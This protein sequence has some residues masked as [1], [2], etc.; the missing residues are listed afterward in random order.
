[1]FISMF[2][3]AARRLSWFVLFASILGIHMPANGSV[4]AA[5]NHSERPNV[6]R[7]RDDARQPL[8]TLT[9]A[10]VQEGDTVLDL[11]AGG[12]WY[13]ELLSRIVGNSGKVFAHNDQVIWSFVKDEMQQRTQGNRLS[14]VVRIDDA[15]IAHISLPENSVDVVFSSLNYHDMYFVSY[16]RN[17]VTTQ[18]REH[19][20]DPVK[21]M[22]HIS[23]LLKDDGHVVIIDH[24]AAEGATPDSGNT[25]HRIHADIVISQMQQAGFERIDEAN[26]LRNPNDNY[27]MSVFD[28]AVRGNTDRFVLKFKKRAT[29]E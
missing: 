9:F 5:I 6:D 1:M 28:K 3:F 14:N 25:V 21:A 22:K 7:E 17:G 23:T 13:T 16:Q 12:G 18:V 4:E 10:D 11:Y 2:T 24:Q 15:E 29:T 8:K 26:H 20:V 27:A 19:P